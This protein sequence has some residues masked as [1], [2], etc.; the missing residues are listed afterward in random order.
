MN[1]NHIIIGMKNKTIVLTGGGTAGHVIPAL[2]IVDELKKYYSRVVYLG[3]FEGIE[4]EL[5]EKSGLEYYG[6]TTVKFDRGRPLANF[7][8]PSQLLKGRMEAI[9]ILK[10]IN[11]DIVF[12]KGGYASLPTV[13][14]SKKLGIPIVLHES[15]YSLGL[16]NKL[17]LSF[18]D[19]LLISFE[20]THKKG[21]LTGNPIRKEIFNGEGSR[22]SIDNGKPVLL[23]VGGSSGARAIDECLTESIPRLSDY[24]VIHIKGKAFETK[25]RESYLPLDYVDNIWDYY[26]RA[27]MVVTRAGANALSELVALGKRILAIPLPKGGS[28]GDQLLN[29]EYY[30]K[31]GKLTVL[32]QEELSP[33]TLIE[34]ISRCLKEKEKTPSYE[35]NIEKV[36]R[37]I[38][39]IG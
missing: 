15:D 21:I 27:D 16:A 35:T 26:K 7:R 24:Y 5:A 22:V 14:A 18:C 2:A 28:R 36:V 37:E 4:K 13:L 39:E 31:A 34:S 25:E 38:V 17:C 11:A 3:R 19:K 1:N 23:F 30:E 12:S 8:I 20:D 33:D 29:A 10:D 32:K 6:T 9:K